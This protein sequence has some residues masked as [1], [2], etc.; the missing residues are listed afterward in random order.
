MESETSLLLDVTVAFGLAL[1]G[2][3]IATRL[4]L[5]AIVGYIAAGAIISP[6][7]PGFVGDTERLRLL[8]DIGVVLL[9]FAIG[10]QFTVADLMKGGIRV[11]VVAVAATAAGLAA[12]LAA[13][14]ALGWSGDEAAFA[15]A[16]A[17][18]SSSVVLVTLLERR[19]ETATDHGR[20]SIGL[21][22]VQDLLAVVLIIVLQVVT[23]DR[24]GGTSDVVRETAWAALKAALFVV[25]V[26]LVGVRLV[27]L[28]LNRV[29]D[30]RS[31]ELFFLAIAIL[32]IGTAF[33]SEQ[34]GLSIA[35]GAFLAGI[36]VSESDLSHRVLGELLPIRDVFAV[37][38]F[39]TAGMLID[40]VVLSDEWMTIVG[41][42]FIILVVRP[43]ATTLV[44]GLTRY[45]PRTA[46]MTAALTAPAAE[47][48]FLLAGT[49]LDNGALDESFFSAIITAAVL[50]I[51]LSPFMA[52]AAE[53]ITQTSAAPP[54][55]LTTA[56]PSRL[57]RR[58]I[59]CGYNDVG[60]IIA[61]ILQARFEVRV[62]EGD[63][64]TARLARER[65]LDVL[66]GSPTSPTVLE[67]A[68]IEDARVVVIALDDPFATRLFAERARQINPHVD[69]VAR[70]LVP[71]E[72]TKLQASDIDTVVAEDEVAFELAR[73]GLHRFGLSTRESLAII[74]Q[75]RARARLKE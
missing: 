19:G 54:M 38:F 30:E 61:S 45:T 27:P 71:S 5:P 60:Q 75:F 46:V 7:T 28:V 35:L 21:S 73:Y 34:I 24:T 52:M 2:G 3:W 41:I 11:V 51:L 42:T 15:G 9:L 74:Q 23:E 31:R 29:A 32:V 59:V 62:I 56:P 57:G 58:A 70:A 6:F 1:A 63:A 18:I 20:A 16:A 69:I 65:D 8:G 10:V 66:E 25:G 64:T 43:G 22:I 12:G 49:G 50:S 68:G 53:R 17:A 36:L 55:E 72:A 40:P 39:V 67:H 13:G 48:S 37:L 33:A 47:F 44:M 26:L 14:P 4:R